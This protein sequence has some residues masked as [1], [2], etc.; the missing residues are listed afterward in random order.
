MWST[1]RAD[2]GVYVDYHLRPLVVQLPSYIK[3][4]KDF[5]LKISSLGPL[6]PYSIL[7][8][9]DVSSLYTNIPHAEAFDSVPHATLMAKLQQIGLNDHILTWIGDYLTG[10]E[11]RVTV[12]GSTSQYSVVLSGVPQGSVLGPLLFFIYVDDLARIPLSASSEAVLYADDLL[13]F[14]PIHGMEDFHYLQHDISA[15]EGWVSSNYLTFNSAKYKYMIV[16]RKANPSSPARLSLGNSNLEKV[17]C[18]KYLGLL[19]SSNLSFS[20]HIASIC[21]KARRITGLL[22]RRFYHNANS[23]TLL[24]LYRSLVRPHL[25]YASPVWNPY[26]HKDTKLLENVRKVCSKNDHTEMRCWLS[27]APRYTWY[28]ITRS[29]CCTDKS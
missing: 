15:I 3:D 19:L 4:T 25:E 13:L 20:Q 14:R 8:T 11:Q 10:R 18:F 9:L 21:T 5:V 24:Q 29:L 22:Y 2:L 27:R 6:P 28:T 17:E 1:Y 26:L 7:L 23:D 16:S 12:S